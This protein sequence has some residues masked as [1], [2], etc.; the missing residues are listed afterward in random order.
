MGSGHVFVV[1]E[2]HVR[3][4]TPINSC[5]FNANWHEHQKYLFGKVKCFLMCM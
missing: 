2:A 5:H 1:L 3:M 4:L